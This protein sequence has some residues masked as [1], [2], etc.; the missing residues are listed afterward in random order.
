MKRP[1]PSVA[2]IPNP[3]SFVF[4]VLSQ[5]GLDGRQLLIT[6]REECVVLKRKLKKAR[7][8]VA[9]LEAS[10]GSAAKTALGGSLEAH[11]LISSFLCPPP[12]L[13][14]SLYWIG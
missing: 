6:S 2:V 8:R 14:V 9:E 7:D 11:W 10:A 5:G 4:F 3:A 13:I 12:N 1:G